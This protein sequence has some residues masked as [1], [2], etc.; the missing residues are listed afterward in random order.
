MT[1]A[2]VLVRRRYSTINPSEV[3]GY[4]VGLTEH[5]S[6]NGHIIWYGGGEARREPDAAQAASSMG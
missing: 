4:A 3:T 6:K 1:Q 5:T 2:G